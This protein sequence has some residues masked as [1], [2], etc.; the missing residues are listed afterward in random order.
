MNH[1]LAVELAHLREQEVMR[2]ALERRHLAEA[3][4]R[5]RPRLVRRGRARTLPAR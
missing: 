4:P 2:R 3:E 1:H 5:P